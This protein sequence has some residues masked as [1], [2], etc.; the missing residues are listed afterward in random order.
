MMPYQL[1]PLISALKNVFMT[2][3]PS[4]FFGPELNPPKI[5]NFRWYLINLIF[6]VPKVSKTLKKNVTTRNVRFF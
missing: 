3:G 4:A 6:R 5:G 2:V 1:I